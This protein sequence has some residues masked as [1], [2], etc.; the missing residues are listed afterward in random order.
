MSEYVSGTWLAV[1]DRCGFQ[2]RNTD[3]RLEWTGLRVCPSCYDER[4]P[5]EFMRGK[6]DRQAPPWT[7]PPPAPIHPFINDGG[8][9]VDPAVDL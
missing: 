3:V 6:P 8:T 1:C 2:R 7:R 4:H 9:D 5:Q